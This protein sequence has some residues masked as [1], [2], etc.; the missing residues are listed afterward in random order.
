VLGAKVG[1]DQQRPAGD[2]DLQRGVS[3]E[4]NFHDVLGWVWGVGLAER[5][6]F[7]EQLGLAKQVGG[8]KA[9]PAS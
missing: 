1:V 7:T 5:V 3:E 8:R 9:I 2:L 6:G 4:T